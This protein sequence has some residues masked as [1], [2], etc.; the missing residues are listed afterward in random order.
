[1][2]VIEESQQIPTHV[3]NAAG[4]TVHPNVDWC[5]DHKEDF[6]RV[7]VC[8]TLSVADICVAKDVHCMMF[9]TG[10]IFEYDESHP[11]GSGVG[12]TEEE[13]PNFTGSYYSK[14][15]G[16]VDSLLRDYERKRMRSSCENAN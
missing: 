6:I 13:L 16:M 7:N 12:F 9:A 5:E 4:L 11:L 3:F 8:G 2:R 10:C 15:K 14:T 1:M